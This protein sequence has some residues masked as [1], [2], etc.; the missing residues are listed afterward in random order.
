MKRVCDNLSKCVSQERF[1]E[2]SKQFANIK[3]SY[4]DYKIKLKNESDSE[5]ITNFTDSIID[6][7]QKCV[8]SYE[9]AKKR[10]YGQ[11]SEESS[12][13]I[14]GDHGVDLEPSSSVSQVIECYSTASSKAMA[15]QIELDR[16]RAELKTH[17]DLAKA[18]AHAEAKAAEAEAK[19]AETEAHRRVEEAR[20]DAEKQLIALSDRGSSVAPSRRQGSVSFSGPSGVPSS[21]SESHR[22][23]LS[24]VVRRHEPHV[25]VEPA[26]FGFRPNEVQP[27]LP[28]EDDA[29]WDD[30]PEAGWPLRLDPDLPTDAL[31]RCCHKPFPIYRENLALRTYLDRQGRSEFINLASQIGYDGKNMTFVFYENQIRKL[32]DESSCNERRLEVLRASCVDQ[33]CEIVNLFLAPIKNMST[34]QHVEKALDRLRQRY[35]VS[36]GL[37][38]EPITIA[39]SNG[40]KVTFNVASLKAFNDD[41]KTLEVFAY[42]HNEVEK[43]SG[44]LLLDNASRLPSV[45]KRRYLNYLAKMGFDLNHPGF[46]SLREFVTHELSVMTSHYAQR[47]FKNDEKDKPRDFKSV[48]DSFRFPQVAVKSKPTS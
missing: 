22:G 36:N 41:L 47:F 18:K 39:I 31:E 2:L 46:Y 6:Q 14:E 1:L 32:M 33:P 37:T 3:I 19:A 8:N 48:R 13:A 24:S 16:K 11:F 30:K 26:R 4:D 34:S 43:L 27:S 28:T 35:G 5:G 21:G 9:S 45:L 42:A 44:Q 10:C 17:Y 12:V 20:L 38:T 7:R 15:R 23:A 25:S 29:H 40:P